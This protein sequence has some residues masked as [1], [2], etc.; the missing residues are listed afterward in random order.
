MM[1]SIRSGTFNLMENGTGNGLHQ[2]DGPYGIYVDLKGSVFIADSFNLS[3]RWIPVS[4]VSRPVAKGS[5][6]Q[7][8]RK[9]G[10][11]RAI[12]NRR[13]KLTGTTFRHALEL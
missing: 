11:A 10:T 6:M 7:S 12:P 8:W 3:P 2:L 9:K 5:Q 4:R 13:G 1:G